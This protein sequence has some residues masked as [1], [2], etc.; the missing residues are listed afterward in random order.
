M[1][2]ICA[3][4]LRHMGE[5]YGR[6]TRRDIRNVCGMLARYGGDMGEIWAKYERDVAEM[7]ARYGR[8]MGEIW[9]RYG[10]DKGGIWGEIWGIVHPC[11]H[12]LHSTVVLSSDGSSAC[13]V[14]Y[15]G[16]DATGLMDVY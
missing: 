3:R 8:D 7:W 13:S 12:M 6:D 14:S 4:C 2:E 5:I 10:R 15:S 11:M 9:A 1:G 16:S